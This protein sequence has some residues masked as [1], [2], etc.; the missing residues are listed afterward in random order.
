MKGKA[1][2]RP[3]RADANIYVVLDAN[4]KSIGTGTK[5]VCEVLARLAAHE[6]AMNLST[7]TVPGPTS[8]GNVRSATTI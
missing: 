3:L 2:I 6:V 5:E 4:G 1:Q 7:F 8:G